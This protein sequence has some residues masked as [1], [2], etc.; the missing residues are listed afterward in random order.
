MPY[1][2]SFANI[3]ACRAKYTVKSTDWGTVHMALPAIGA[4]T[5]AEV[6]VPVTKRFSAKGNVGYSRPDGKTDPG[7]V[8]IAAVDCVAPAWPAST[9]VTNAQ[10][11]PNWIVVNGTAFQCTTAGTTAGTIPAGLTTQPAAGVTVT[12]NTAVW[13][14]K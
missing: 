4:N 11:T 7:A 10:P 3:E 2:L 5:T 8:S 9:A 12:D 13:T 6:F 1:P 14:S